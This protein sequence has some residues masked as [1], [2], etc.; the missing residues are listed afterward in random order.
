MSLARR[1]LYLCDSHLE[2]YGNMQVFHPHYVFD[3]LGW[4]PNQDKEVLCSRTLRPER[5]RRGQS[6]RRPHRSKRN[7]PES[8]GRKPDPVLSPFNVSVPRLNV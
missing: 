7:W 2:I 4:F 5:R 8:R 1:N 6:G 3:L